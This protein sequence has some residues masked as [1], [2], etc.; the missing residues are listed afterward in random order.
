MLVRG[1]P[2]D[3]L[4]TVRNADYLGMGGIPG[5]IQLTMWPTKT[6]LAGIGYAAAP[7]SA[8]TCATPTWSGT[9]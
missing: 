4:L 9:R 6:S 3:D 7:E 5:A 1:D 2:D 8:T